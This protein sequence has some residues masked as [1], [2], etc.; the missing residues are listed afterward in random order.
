MSLLTSM[1]ADGRHKT[2]LCTKVNK[3]KI[4]ALLDPELLPSAA[5]QLTERQ[6]TNS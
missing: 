5:M 3:L 4:E 2:I 1:C 6:E